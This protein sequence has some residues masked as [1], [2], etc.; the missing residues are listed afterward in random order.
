M[1]EDKLGGLGS[2]RIKDLELD[3]LPVMVC[4]RYTRVYHGKIV[5]LALRTGAEGIS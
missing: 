3:M 5:Q 2:S 4:Q 1:L